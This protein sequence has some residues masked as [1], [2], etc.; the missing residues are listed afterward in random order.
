LGA[1]LVFLLHLLQVVLFFL[2]REFG[3][4]GLIP[5]AFLIILGFGIIQAVYVIPAL[6]VAAVKRRWSVLRGIVIAALLTLGIQ[7][8]VWALIFS[9]SGSFSP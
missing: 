7:G 1:S 3:R 9:G 2:L 6:I 5:D 8:A 4:G